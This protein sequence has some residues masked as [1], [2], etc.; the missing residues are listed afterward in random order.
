MTASQPQGAA[1]PAQE[2]YQQYPQQYAPPPRPKKKPEDIISNGL[3]LAVV[4]LSGI[5]FLVG[6]M[7]IHA[8]G[9]L[10]S[11][12]DAELIGNLRTASWMLADVAM[13]LLVFFMVIAAILRDDFHHW[14]RVSLVAFGA[15]ILLYF[16]SAVYGMGP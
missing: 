2:G 11:W 15:V 12:N 8:T 6:A 4:L 13:F 7:M 16:L 3:I 9:F 10:D 5:L 1:P 14:V